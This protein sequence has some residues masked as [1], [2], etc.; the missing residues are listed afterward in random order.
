MGQ[1]QTV[2]SLEQ[3]EQE[4]SHSQPLYPKVLSLAAMFVVSM[5]CS[6]IVREPSNFMVVN[7]LINVPATDY[8]LFENT[9]PLIP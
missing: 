5:T 9:L 1:A 4:S 3:T 6:Y 7:V 8:Q 2:M